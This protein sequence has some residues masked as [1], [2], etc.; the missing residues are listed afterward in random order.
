M[1]QTKLKKECL[2]KEQSN[3]LFKKQWNLVQNELKSKLVE[4]LTELK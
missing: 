1:L 3:K 2:I 4:D